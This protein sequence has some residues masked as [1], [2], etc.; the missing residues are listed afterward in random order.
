MPVQI[1][2]T[3]G[4]EGSGIRKVRFWVKVGEKFTQADTLFEFNK[5]KPKDHELVRDWNGEFIVAG[6]NNS[7]CYT[8]LL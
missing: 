7:S 3:D 2:V 8:S 5:E 4:L 1:N 6:E